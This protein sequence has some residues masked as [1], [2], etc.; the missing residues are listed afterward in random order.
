MSRETV[1]QVLRVLRD[2]P[3]DTLDITGGA[4]ELSPYF[5]MLVAR[6]RAD[7]WMQL[8]RRASSP[9]PPTLSIGVAN[10]QLILSWPSSGT[11]GFALE[12]ATNLA[13]VAIWTPVTNQVSD[14]GTLKTVTLSLSPAAPM[15]FFRLRH[16]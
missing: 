16:D 9:Q 11:G 10:N 2:N 1:E 12:S 4:P 8:A 3:I 6:A 15:R 14:N 7:A 5:Q 13:P